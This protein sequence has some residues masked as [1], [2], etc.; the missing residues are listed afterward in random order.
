MTSE[1]AWTFGLPFVAFF[2]LM[3]VC[4]YGLR[5]I[6]EEPDWVPIRPLRTPPHEETP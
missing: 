2:V 4:W 3:S 6:G 5:R 1:I